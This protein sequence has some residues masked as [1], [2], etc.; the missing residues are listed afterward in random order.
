MRRMSEKQKGKE[1]WMNEMSMEG[2]EKEKNG[3]RKEEKE[4]EN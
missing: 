2:K 4:N 3:R 1:E